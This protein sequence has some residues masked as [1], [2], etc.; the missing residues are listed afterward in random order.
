MVEEASLLSGV[1]FMR[2]LYYLSVAL[3]EYP[4]KKQ[5]KK[6]YV[7]S[8]SFRGDTVHHGAEGMRTGH[9]GQECA[10]HPF[11]HPCTGSRDRA[12]TRI[13]RL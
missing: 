3:T 9:E 4:D 2:M 6:S 1:S 5:L 7:L 10:S 8:S 13:T 12:R 11:L